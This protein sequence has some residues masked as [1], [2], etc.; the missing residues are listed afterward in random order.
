MLEQKAAFDILDMDGNGKITFKEV[1]ARSACLGNGHQQ[2]MNAKLGT[3]M[4]EQE[5]FWHEVSHHECLMLEIAWP[6]F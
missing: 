3:P 6:F 1:Q 4:T 5:L 2:E